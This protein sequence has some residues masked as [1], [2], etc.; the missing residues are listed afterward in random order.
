M[1]VTAADADVLGMPDGVLLAHRYRV[2]HSVSNGWRAYDERLARPVVIERVAAE[3]PPA[4][5]VRRLIATERELFDAVVADDDV[6]AV[7]PPNRQNG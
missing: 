7:F 3:G 2:L 4:E 1:T 5:R 6:F